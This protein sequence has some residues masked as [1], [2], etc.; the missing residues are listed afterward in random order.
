[1]MTREDI[2][3]QI[4]SPPA[5]ASLFGFPVRLQILMLGVAILC[6]AFIA[7]VVVMQLVRPERGSL[8]VVL[9]SFVVCG[10]GF[11]FSLKVLGYS[12]DRIAVSSGGIWYLRKNAPSTYMDWSDVAAVKA[13]DTT[14]RLILADSSGRRTIR[15]EYQIERFAV[16]REFILSHKNALAR[17]APPGTGVFHRTWI[18]KIILAI[19]GL[20]I[21]I[22]SAACYREG[23]AEGFYVTL[24]FGVCAVL[25]IA[26]DPVSLTI[27]AEGLTIK[28]LLWSRSI[29]FA[30]ISGIALQDISSRGNVWAAVVIE[31][32]KKRKI[33][34]YRFREGSLALKD[35]LES[36]WHSSQAIGVHAGTHFE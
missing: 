31:R 18:N 5:D 1:M 35:A 21:W 20:P 25:A 8:M 24:V 32:K 6:L 15:V 28:Y 33:R 9:L 26:A 22:M 2:E 16:L 14:Q 11:A 13:N 34:L 29:P 19:F 3:R 36:A 30:S 10:T 23:V 27:G 7:C 17:Q 4:E 12:R